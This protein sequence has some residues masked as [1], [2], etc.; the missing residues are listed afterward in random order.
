MP[1]ITSRAMYYFG[2]HGWSE[3]DI[4]YAVEHS[5]YIIDKDAYCII[6]TIGPDGVHWLYPVSASNTWPLSLWKAVKKIILEEDNVVIPMNKNTDKVK[7]GAKRYNGYLLDNLYMFGEELKGI[8]EIP[9]I[10]NMGVR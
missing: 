7:Q 4:D 8:K 5:T 10:T 3:S 9:G 6:G 2:T 1:V